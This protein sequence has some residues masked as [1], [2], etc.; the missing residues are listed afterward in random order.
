MKK[1]RGN[2]LRANCPERNPHWQAT[3]SAPEAETAI[4]SEQGGN[5]VKGPSRD[6][7]STNPSG[8]K[9]SHQHSSMRG[10]V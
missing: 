3:V 7:Y 5:E 9:K 6:S 2:G 1:T 8:F 4:C 10:G